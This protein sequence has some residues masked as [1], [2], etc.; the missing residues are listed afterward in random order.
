[1]N[2]PTRR[3]VLCALLAATALHG[4]GAATVD[5]AG[6]VDQ[7]GQRTIAALDRLGGDP[8]A[9][10]QAI[11]ALLDETVDLALIARLCLGRHWRTAGKEQ[12]TQYVDLF[13]A[14][15]LAVLSR[16]MSYY[17]GGEKFVVTASRPARDDAMVAS[18]IIYATNDPPLKIEWRVR[19]TDGR[20]IIIDVLP[21][22]VSLVL[23]YRSEFDEVVARSGMDGLLAELRDRAVARAKPA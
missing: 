13:R 5:A 18:E 21:E 20:P 7:L 11:S 8:A 23:T 17:T 15:V 1:M 10:R 6:F 22:G 2:Q 12:R 16:R 14:N 4:A 3:T 19:V 9:R